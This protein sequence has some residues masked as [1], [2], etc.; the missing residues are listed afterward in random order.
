MS[1][2]YISSAHIQFLLKHN[3]V[4][5]DPDALLYSNMVVYVTKQQTFLYISV[6][7]L[8]ATRLQAFYFRFNILTHM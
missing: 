5:E 3:I 2:I 1:E 8:L 6:I 4:N 7:C